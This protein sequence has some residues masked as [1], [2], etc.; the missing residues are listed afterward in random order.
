MREVAINVDQLSCTIVYLFVSIYNDNLF[1]CA[2]RT[3]CYTVEFLKR[4]VD[5]AFLKV[6]G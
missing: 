2:M 4:Y 3:E 5:E 6:I 1:R